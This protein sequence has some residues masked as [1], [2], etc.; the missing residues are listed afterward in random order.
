MLFGKETLER[1]GYQ[2]VKKNFEDMF[3]PF[4]RIHERDTRTHTDGHNMTTYRPRL[5]SIARQKWYHSK[6]LV[7]FLHP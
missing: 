2:T 4:D 1:L 3:I 6:A 7:R 5:H